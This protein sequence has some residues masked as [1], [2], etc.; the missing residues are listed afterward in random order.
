M[1]LCFLALRLAKKHGV[2]QVVGAHL[3]YGNR[4]EV[5]IF[6]FCRNNHSIKRMYRVVPSPIMWND[7]VNTKG[8]YFVYVISLKLVEQRKK[9]TILRRKKTRFNVSI[10]ELQEMI[11]KKN[12]VKLDSIFINKYCFGFVVC[13]VC[14][15]MIHSP[16]HF[17]T[18]RCWMNSL[19]LVSFL[20]IMLAMFVKMSLLM[21]WKDMAF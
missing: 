5:C 17:F 8:W 3:D 21:Q 15:I 9:W 10:V 19:R 20:D 12:L 6:L 13:L 16:A 1:V 7:G 11:M 2:K 14:S 4:P 18:S